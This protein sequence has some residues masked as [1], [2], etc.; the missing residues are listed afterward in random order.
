LPRLLI[1]AGIFHPEP[2]GPATY[3]HEI[4]PALQSCGWEVQVVTYGEAS[5]ATY[6]YPVTRISRRMLPLSRLK[7]LLAAGRELAHTDL[8]YAHT[9]DL[10]L[11][12]G[13][14]PR[15]IKI[16][17]D[18]AWERCIR[19]GWIPSDND[20]DEFQRQ[21]YGFRAEWQKRSRSKQ[22]RAM[23]GV[24]VPAAYLKR[25]VAGWGVPEDRIEVVYNAL[26]P[27]LLQTLPTQAEARAQFGWDAAPTI[28]TAARLTPW[29]GIDHLITAL[30]SVPEVR[31]VVAGEGDDLP[32]LRALAE[33]LAARVIFTGR[34]P[35]ETLYTAMRAADYFALY[36][37]YEGLPHTLLESLRAGTPIIAS[38]RGGNPEVAQPGINGFVVPY[39]DL[40]ALIET[41][42][43]AIK[44]GVREALS[45]RTGTGMERFAFATMVKET[46]RVLREYI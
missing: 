41:L 37:G 36:S 12:G 21:R 22:V 18:Q 46:D 4:L 32:R 43:E 23:N 35:R 6:P 26:P 40:P 10:P 19:K 13:D 3:L 29:K 9:I 33:P 7:Y 2:G 11:Y 39:V 30:K 16:V 28:L 34:L 27:M 42:R 31:L 14:A 38:D 1:A 45:A 25:M 17:G 5:A 15:L 24:I 8:V 44:P 20:I